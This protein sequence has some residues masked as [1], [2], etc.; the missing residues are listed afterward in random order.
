ME[1]S[2]E[3]SAEL[4]AADYGL[5]RYLVRC[6]YDGDPYLCLFDSTDKVRV[7][8]ERK[9][10]DTLGDIVKLPEGIGNVRLTA[11]DAVHQVRYRDAGP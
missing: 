7:I 1:K 11:L 4:L 6:V 2:E 5:D 3:L 9:I 8:D 10:P